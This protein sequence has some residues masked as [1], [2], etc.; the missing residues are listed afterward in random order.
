MS[1]N[2]LQRIVSNTPSVLLVIAYS[3]TYLGDLGSAARAA[4][5]PQGPPAVGKSDPVAAERFFHDQRA[6]P[7]ARI[8]PGALLEARRQLAERL[9]TGAIPVAPR[10]GAA[11]AVSRPFGF[12]ANRP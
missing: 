4:P 2:R 10:E 12:P 6:A 7:G 5:A 8:K 1:V 9:R 3:F 11:A